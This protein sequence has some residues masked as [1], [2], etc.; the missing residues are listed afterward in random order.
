MRAAS[1]ISGAAKMLAL[2]KG[3]GTVSMGAAFRRN[4]I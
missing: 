2:R 4:I 1:F 3:C